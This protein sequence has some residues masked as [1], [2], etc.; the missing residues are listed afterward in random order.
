MADN[1]VMDSKQLIISNILATYAWLSDAYAIPDSFTTK[2]S[3]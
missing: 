2:P 1:L 3:K